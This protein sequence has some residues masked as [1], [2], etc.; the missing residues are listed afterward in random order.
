MGG[1]SAGQIASELALTTVIRTYYADA[2]TDFEAA[3][4]RA[5]EAANTYIV[6]VARMIPG[7]QGMGTTLTAAVVREDS[8]YVAHVGD[9]RMYLIRAGEIRQLTEDHSWVAE[10]VRRGAMTLEEAEQ[11][12]YRNMITRSLGAADTVEP[13]ILAVEL[14]PGDRF[15][16]CSDGLSGMVS[17]RELLDLGGAGSPSTAAW[18]LVDRAN[19]MGGKDNITVLILDVQELGPYQEL[20][21]APAAPAS[22]DYGRGEED[23]SVDGS[24]ARAPETA[25]EAPRRGLMRTLFGRNDRGT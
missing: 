25:E 10:Q 19:L 1:H 21:R 13:D 14:R 24:A 11:S 18:N 12:P 20:E 15:L 3:L 17:D 16:L 6:E 5:M 23:P 22:L 7:R 8:L 4:Q 9:S 2:D